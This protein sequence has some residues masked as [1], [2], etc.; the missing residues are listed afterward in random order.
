MSNR[1]IEHNIPA[2][3]CQIP[4]SPPHFTLSSPTGSPEILTPTTALAAMNSTNNPSIFGGLYARSPITPIDQVLH[5]PPTPPRLPRIPAPAP[6]SWVRLNMQARMGET[7]PLDSVGSQLT[8]Y[9]LDPNCT[10]PVLRPLEIPAGD[11]EARTHHALPSPQ[12]LSPFE[13]PKR[14]LFCTTTSEVTAV[15]SLRPV[16][17]RTNSSSRLT[18]AALLRASGAGLARSSSI[19]ERPRR[20][21]SLSEHRAIPPYPH[22][23]PCAMSPV[24]QALASP[25]MIR[26]D[27]MEGGYFSHV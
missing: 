18:R 22:V 27:T 26:P 11:C 9:L 17:S 4:I 1:R 19:G 21:G 3:R 14:L 25:F 23:G 6:R 13:L 7:S 10:K 5:T 8:P 16:L 12:T 20:A 24:G 15:K 2:L